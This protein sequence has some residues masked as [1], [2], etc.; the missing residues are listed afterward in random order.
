MKTMLTLLG[1]CVIT[2]SSAAEKEKR[3]G[4]TR[5][6]VVGQVRAPKNMEVGPNMTAD[7][8]F[9]AA[10]ANEFSTRRRL[11]VLRVNYI[12]EQGAETTVRNL[13]LLPE[14]RI[15]DLHLLDGDIVCI[16]MKPPVGG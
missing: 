2:L 3:E 4:L 6:Q 10:G 15:S 8:F 12:Y 9:K 14:S 13:E 11:I 7:E 1:I 5:I 16:V